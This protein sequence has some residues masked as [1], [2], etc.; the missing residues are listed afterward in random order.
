ML[1]NNSI[2]TEG[3]YIVSMS[4]TTNNNKGNTE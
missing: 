4:Q 2:M 1:Y 3:I